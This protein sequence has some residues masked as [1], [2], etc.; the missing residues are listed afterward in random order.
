[1]IKVCHMTSAHQPGDTRIFQKECVSLAKAGYQVFLVQRGESGENSGVRIIG[2]GQPSGGRL[3]RMTAFSKKVYETARALDADIYHFHD[4]FLTVW[5]VNH[6]CWQVN[7][8][9]PNA[10]FLKAF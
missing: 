9:Q 8:F 10:V 2:V 3:T 6:S 4:P 5:K 7:D 1:M